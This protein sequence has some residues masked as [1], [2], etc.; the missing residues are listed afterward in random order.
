[1]A[2]LFCSLAALVLVN[3]VSTHQAYRYGEVSQVL[4]T[5][6]GED[7]RISGIKSKFK[8]DFVLGGLLHIHSEDPSKAGGK[9]GPIRDDEELEAM[10]FAIDSIN[11]DQT[12]IP[13]VTFGFDVRDTCYSENIALDETVDLI[14][15]G[16]ELYPESCEPL[17]NGA[18]ETNP[19]A[20]GS[21][22]SSSLYNK[23]TTL[24]LIGAEASRV[25]RPVASLARLFR[26]PQI[27]PASSSPSLSNRDRYTYF[28][29][30][31]PPDDLQ[32][33]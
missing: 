11:A 13:N 10:L 7:R 12:L 31:I 1:M 25:S 26:V 4:L 20:S 18:G 33:S 9:C 23:E 28:Y 24:G 19:N 8:T 3:C 5:G 30:T 15:A 27:S 17:A 14:I 2:V 21:A 16:S 29:R 22:S 32:V 6:E